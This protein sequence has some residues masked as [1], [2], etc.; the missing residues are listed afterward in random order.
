MNQFDAR[1]PR[2]IPSDDNH[3][4]IRHRAN[5][6]ADVPSLYDLYAQVSKR[7]PVLARFGEDVFQNGTGN[8]DELPMDFRS[9]RIMCSV[10]ETA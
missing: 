5:P 2:S 6:Y 7:S 4:V 9:V 8:F 1:F 3:P 10:R